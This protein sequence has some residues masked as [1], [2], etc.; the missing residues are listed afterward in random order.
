MKSEALKPKAVMLA[1][2]LL[3]QPL[4]A[5]REAVG[6]RSNWSLTRARVGGPPSCA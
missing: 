2:V 4:F 3:R 1:R 6:A 5:A